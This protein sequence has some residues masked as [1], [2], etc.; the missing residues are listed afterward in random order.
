[1]AGVAAATILFAGVHYPQYWGDWSALI[2][3]TLLSLTLTL[4]RV[5]SSN[6]LP[7]IILHTVFNSIQSVIIIAE[8]FFREQ[9]NNAPQQAA[10]FFH[11]L[12]SNSL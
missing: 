10:F 8:P 4:I 7:C 5:K 2:L 6:L 3:I 11:F 12:K 1:M 9:S